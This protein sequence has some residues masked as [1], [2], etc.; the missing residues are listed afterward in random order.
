MRKRPVAVTVLSA[1]KTSDG[2]EILAIALC[3]LVE[4]L[5]IGS[6]AQL[7][8]H[9]CHAPVGQC[10][11]QTPT[12]SLV[13]AEQ[14]AGN[15]AILLEQRQTSFVEHG[16]GFHGLEG[17]LALG[18]ESFQHQVGQYGNSRIAHHAVGLAAHEVPH[19]QLT[20]LSP[21]VDHRLGD[22]FLAFG[23]YECHQRMGSTI[24][25]PQREGGVVHIVALMY[26][27]VG[28][29][30]L[31]IDITEH[32]GRRHGVIQGCI[33]DGALVGCAASHL[34]LLQLLVPFTFGLGY[35]SVEVPVCLLCPQVGPCP[36]DA[37]GRE[38]HT[39]Q[40]G[41]SVGLEANH[42]GTY[43]IDIYRGL[44]VRFGDGCRVAT[45]HVDRL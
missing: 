32:R 20:L 45:Y 33:E 31:S 7:F 2:V 19:R 39:H 21:D 16:R 30:I 28:A 8:R 6:H 22:V 26:L 25:V 17:L 11:F 13:V 29:T 23:V 1:H 40:Q 38:S 35:H 36:V 3:P 15:I 9:T 18:G 12:Y 5:L 14:V 43:V 37:D 10:I 4:I 41:F 34:Y 24:G 42:P 44:V 27:A